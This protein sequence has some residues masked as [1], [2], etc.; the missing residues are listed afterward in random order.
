ML[1]LFLIRCSNKGSDIK[2]RL[3]ELFRAGFSDVF[4]GK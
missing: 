4:I 1:K 3:Q 2:K